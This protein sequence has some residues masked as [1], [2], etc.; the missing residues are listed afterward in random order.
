MTESSYV[1]FKKMQIQRDGRE[2]FRS[3]ASKWWKL[4]TL[5]YAAK[6]VI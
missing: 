4:A 6:Y 5:L 1:F 2:N 3:I